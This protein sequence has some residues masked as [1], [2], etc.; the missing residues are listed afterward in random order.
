MLTETEVS[1]LFGR[2]TRTVR[3]WSEAKVLPFIQVGGTRYYHRDSVD[4]FYDQITKF[5]SEVNQAVAEG[6]FPT[7]DFASLMARAIKDMR[8]AKA[9]GQAD[10]PA[11]DTN[12]AA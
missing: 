9:S 10:E 3:R 6:W 11:H 4:A 12:T 5:V 2:S 7:S 1:E 8:E